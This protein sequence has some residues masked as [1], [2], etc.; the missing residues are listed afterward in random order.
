M[1]YF[2]KACGKDGKAGKSELEKHA[3][4]MKH[5]SNVEARQKTVSVLSMPAFSGKSRQEKQVKESEIRLAAYISE[6]NAPFT[7]MEHLVPLIQAVCPDSEIAKKLKCGRTKCA[8]VVKNILGAQKRDDVHELLRNYPFSLIVDEST[9]IG[10]TKHLALVARVATHDGVKDIFLALVPVESTTAVD[11][12]NH[13][14]TVFNDANIPYLKNM[15]GFAADGANVMMGVNNSLSTLLKADIPNLFIMKCICHSFNLCASYACKCLPRWI[16]DLIRDVHNYFLSPKQLGNLKEFQEF[17][18]TKPHKLLHPCQTRW[19]SLHSAVKRLLDQLPALKLFFIHAASEDRLL[20]AETILQKLNDPAAK[21]YLEFLDF[22]LPF[23]N[24]LNKEMQSEDPKLF[25]MHK[26]V[27][28]ILSTILECYI[29]QDYLDVTPVC[30]V[31]FRDPANFLPLKEIYLGGRVTSSLCTNPDL[32]KQLIHNF[33]LRCLEF[34]IEG[35]SQIL[36][37]IKLSDPVLQN[38]GAMD[39]QS[40]LKKTVK[41]IVPLACQF[42]NMVAVEDLNG[43]DSE[44][45]LLRNTDLG[46]DSDISMSDFW[47][48]VKKMKKHDSPLFPLLGSFMMKLMCLPHSSAAVER[49]FSQINLVKTKTRNK[50]NTAT[51]NGLLHAKETFGFANCYDFE[52]RPSHLSRMTEEIYKTAEDPKH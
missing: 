30:S 31:H 7:S 9:D 25:L 28:T 8:A 41:S 21:L 27:T 51:L 38:L 5:I 17:A 2:C 6:H 29:K 24:D 37:R 15:V 35:V 3:M 4:G 11:L 16:E 12:Y 48:K 14:K 49:I 50:L 52:I 45:R 18:E 44:W 13:V 36:K 42:P 33:R 46:F 22:V 40:I 23:F 26:R 10:C 34:Y 43:L 39:P 20:A 19:L 1:Y 32:D 47:L